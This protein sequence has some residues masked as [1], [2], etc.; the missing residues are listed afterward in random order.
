MKEHIMKDSMLVAAVAVFSIAI[1]MVPRGHA[2]SSEAPRS[3]GYIINLSEEW[4]S[5]HDIVLRFR[6]NTSIEVVHSRGSQVVDT[7]DISYRTELNVRRTG[8]SRQNGMTETTFVV[9]T[10]TRQ[11]SGAT[12]ELCPNGSRLVCVTGP[13]REDVFLN[14]VQI[15]GDLSNALSEAISPILCE[16]KASRIYESSQR[17]RVG[18]SWS[19]NRPAAARWLLAEQGTK[20]VRPENFTGTA[21]LKGLVQC[22][23]MRC[24]ELE[25]DLCN[26]G[27]FPASFDQDEVIEARGHWRG[28]MI[29]PLVTLAPFPLTES[30]ATINIVVNR[31]GLRIA[32]K[33]R[34]TL[35]WETAVSESTER[36]TVPN[37]GLRLICVAHL[38]RLGLCLRMFAADHEGR[39]PNDL[40]DLVSE[41]YLTDLD[42]WTCPGTKT[43]PASS[44]VELCSGNHCDYLY[45]GKRLTDDFGC[46][47]PKKAI[48]CCDKPGNHG[49]SLNVCFGD[50]RVKVYSGTNIEAIADEHGLF[51][52]G[53]NMTK[54]EKSEKETVSE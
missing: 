41:K 3:E 22:R 19:I 36:A 47:D 40:A 15:D 42:F 31:D 27:A 4:P 53:H 49:H 45:F 26:K 14:G 21:T 34:K 24:F 20:G 23:D 30:N 51:L 17:R 29:V 44:L 37:E 12:Q 10:F 2:L 13:S 52:P 39:F 1:V 32:A 38:K 6:G 33:M 8:T 54:K 11:K 48:L 25:T 28:R 5:D 16:A 46:C 9:D 43:K 35:V 7:R 50:G 18:E